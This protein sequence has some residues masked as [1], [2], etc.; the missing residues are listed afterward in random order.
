MDLFRP[1]WKNSNSWVRQAAVEK[2][3]DQAVLA[4]IA[5]TDGDNDVRKA[6]V[7][8]LTDQ[9]ALAEVAKNIWR[10]D[11]QMA[12]VAKLTDQV[13]LA[14]IAKTCSNND[15]RQAALGKLTDQALLAEVAKN[16][17][18][19]EVQMAAVAK[20]TDQAVIAK[21]AKTCSKY[22]REAA[23]E[24][25]IDQAVL[26]EIATKDSDWNVRYAAVRKLTDQ[27]L[28]AEI[29]TKDSDW[30]VRY[31]A[32]RKLTDQAL[33]AEIAKTDSERGVRQAAVKNLTDQVVLAQIAKTD[34][35]RGVRQAAVKK[36]TDEV[37]L[38]EI[39][40]TDSIGVWRE[41]AIA[42]LAEVSPGS[43]LRL[44][45]EFGAGEEWLQAART[46]L[47]DKTF[48]PANITQEVRMELATGAVEPREAAV[49]PLRAILLDR[50]DW[51]GHNPKAFRAARQQALCLALFTLGRIGS[52]QAIE[53]ILDAIAAV[54]R[55]GDALV[56]A[57]REP[58]DRYV[59][60]A[61]DVTLTAALSES[62]NAISVDTLRKIWRLQDY[63]RTEFCRDSNP[64][65]PEEYYPDREVGTYLEFSF[66]PLRDLAAKVLAARGVESD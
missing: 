37:A 61:A 25:L 20:L 26:A 32:V 21:V 4:E 7:A 63:K 42:R 29:A 54:A 31:A 41:A 34:S 48:R 36:L 56:G 52:N 51:Y 24:K 50:S 44:A 53:A 46:L 2:L 1:K 27:A 10:P 19:A 60:P 18:R 65:D 64:N 55:S 59:L 30:N 16:G 35:E 3:T 14:E 8:K 6:A 66:A 49:G 38:A 62:P 47:E 5:G 43:A 15:I 45:L 22:A 57:W 58:G 11:V 17:I 39:A 23:V 33:L 12:A 40:K 9:A 13:V 28:L